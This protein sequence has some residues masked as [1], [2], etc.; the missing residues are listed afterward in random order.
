MSLHRQ[1]IRSKTLCEL[2][3][4]LTQPGVEENTACLAESCLRDYLNQQLC[5]H[6]A[7]S[8]QIWLLF[9]IKDTKPRLF[10]NRTARGCAQISLKTILFFSAAARPAA[11]RS[12]LVF[13]TRAIPACR[14]V[15]LRWAGLTAFQNP[16]HVARWQ[17][18]E[19][20][21]STSRFATEARFKHRQLGRERFPKRK[22]YCAEVVM[23]SL[24]TLCGQVA[25]TCLLGLLFL[26]INLGV[27]LAFA[28][29]N[30]PSKHSPR[31]ERSMA[32]AVGKQTV[33]LS[34]A[35]LK[36]AHLPSVSL[37]VDCLS[38]VKTST[39]ARACLSFLIR[40]HSQCT[41]RCRSGTCRPFQ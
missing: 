7:T 23:W 28:P 36:E 27:G 29:V 5:L 4:K 18:L 14:P 19:L 26:R 8:P 25:C 35:L 15:R 12:C 31:F 16:S 20:S 33:C 37:N 34:E 40:S 32:S 39:L 17:D 6:R 22:A 11:Q 24:L 30:K 9:V 2:Q 1:W 13:V 3:I 21:W 10:K 41:V 38:L